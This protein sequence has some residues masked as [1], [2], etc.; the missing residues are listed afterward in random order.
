MVLEEAAR[1]DVSV[2]F[3]FVYASRVDDAIV[4]GLCDVVERHGGR[5]QFVQL[6]C[7]RD[8]LHKRVQDPGRSVM[9][10]LTDITLVREFYE[11]HEL[12]SPIAGRES[13]LIDN[14]HLLPEEAARLIIGQQRSDATTGPG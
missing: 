6:T 2:I 14:T 5:I 1:E 11:R 3:T 4:A 10:K 12:F 8:I 9:G 13:L 7:D